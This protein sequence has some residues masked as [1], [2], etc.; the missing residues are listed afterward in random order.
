MLTPDHHRTI[1]SYLDWWTT[2]G[3]TDA[4]ADAPCNWLSAPPVRAAATRSA[5]PQDRATPPR[6]LAGKAAADSAPAPQLAP[7]PLP[8]PT[9]AAA[10][11]QDPAE[12]SVDWPGDYDSFGTWLEAGDMVPGSQ[13][14]AR[15]VLPL[16]PPT[17]P[18]AI[19][20]AVPEPADQDSGT[21]FAGPAGALL[22]AMLRALGMTLDDCYRA[23]IFPTRPPGGRLDPAMQPMFRA[24]ARHHLGLLGAQRVILL[25]DEVTRALAGTNVADARGRLPII[26]HD[27]TK[28][29]AVACRHPA[30]ML[31][32]PERK[33][34]AW[35]SL[36]CLLRA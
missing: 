13:W 30:V 24:F 29:A 28:L 34:A 20:T 4:V 7:P 16:G 25:G 36:K 8:A 23:A 5:P 27:G 18:L 32:K 14:D 26:N 1:A 9:P 11:I 12:W 31:G 35:A 2:A 19:L 15:R 22:A 10:P 6:P 17:A 3:V 21:L 33:A